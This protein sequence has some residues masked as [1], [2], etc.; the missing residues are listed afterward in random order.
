MLDDS[1]LLGKIVT[2]VMIGMLGWMAYT[3]QQMSVEQA[4]LSAQMSGIKDA[5]TIAQQDR[6][7]RSD[8]L[9]DLSVI[10]S[11]VQRL[12]EWN[13]RLS[14]RLA[15]LEQDVRSGQD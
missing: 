13:A 5:L 12:E 4:V 3:V 11:K 8:A 7:T 14:D 6:Y 10:T 15:S 9:A 2:F 1:N